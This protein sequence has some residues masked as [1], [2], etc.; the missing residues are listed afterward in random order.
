MSRSRESLVLWISIRLALVPHV[1]T[2][3]LTQG[4]DPVVEAI[5]GYRPA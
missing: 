1:P 3:A 2:V 4:L 5:G